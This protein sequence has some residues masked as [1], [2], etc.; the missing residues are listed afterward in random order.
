MPSYNRRIR[1]SGA[2]FVVIAQH[3]EAPTNDDFFRLLCIDIEQPPPGEGYPCSVRHG[4]GRPMGRGL[5]RKWV[6]AGLDFLKKR[7]DFGWAWAWVL[8]LC[9]QCSGEHNLY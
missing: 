3:L 5:G 8:K 1:I 2:N 6:W 9:E 4:L 7:I